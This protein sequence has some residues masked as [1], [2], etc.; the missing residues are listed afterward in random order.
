MSRLFLSSPV[1]LTRKYG[2]FLSYFVPFAPVVTF[3]HLQ[4]PLHRSAVRTAV[5]RESLAITLR[6]RLFRHDVDQGL[7]GF[8][9]R[10]QQEAVELNPKPLRH[11]G[12]GVQVVGVL[13]A[14]RALEPCNPLRL[15]I[16][17]LHVHHL[18]PHHSPLVKPR[19]L[20]LL[21]VE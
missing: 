5:T 8:E 15:P 14:E 19:P 1:I 3:G 17:L 2:S 11:V 7:G 13:D 20:R 21:L 6:F 9:R 16:R 10:A 12:H 4:Q 18:M